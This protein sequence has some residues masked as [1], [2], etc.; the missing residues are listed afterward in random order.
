M[1]DSCPYCI[2][3]QR[4]GLLGCLKHF[5]LDELNDAWGLKQGDT[6]NE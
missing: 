1:S 3:G 5:T 6:T 4:M 2:E